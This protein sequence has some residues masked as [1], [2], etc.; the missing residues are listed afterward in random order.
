MALQLRSV[1]ACALGALLA[2]PPVAAALQPHRAFYRLE[3]GETHGV[4]PLQGVEGGLVIEWRLACD[5]WLSRQRLGFVAATE[6][7]VGLTRDVRFS[8]WEA[9]DGSSLRYTLRSFQGDALEEEFRGEARIE[10][11][12]GGVA[13]FSKPEEVDVRLPGGTIFPTEHLERVL[14]GA[15]RGERLMTHEVFDGWGF[16]SLTQITTVIGEP[17]PLPASA[18]RPEGGRA[19]PISMAYYKI[20]SQSDVPEFE[21]SFLLSADGV[22]RELALDYGDF[23]LNGTLEQL[24]LLGQPGC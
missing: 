11:R 6:D 19:W 21:A 7:G 10:G 17:R 20:D 3:L 4:D 18:G 14:L 16:D 24:D 22:M 9:A 8:S 5:G 12:G 2:A 15:E 23:M 13:S 1:I